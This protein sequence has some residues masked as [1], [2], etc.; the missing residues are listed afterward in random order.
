MFIKPVACVSFRLDHSLRPSTPTN[1]QPS[2]GHRNGRLLSS[3]ADRQ[4]FKGVIIIIIIL[5]IVVCV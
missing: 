1:F 4:K 5:I 3:L 2:F